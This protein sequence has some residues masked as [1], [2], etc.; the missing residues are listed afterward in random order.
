MPTLFLISHGYRNSFIHRRI[1]DLSLIETRP[2]Q[3]ITVGTWNQTPK[4]KVPTVKIARC[5]LDKSESYPI[6][7]V[8]QITSATTSPQSRENVSACDNSFPYKQVPRETTSLLADLQ[9]P[10]LQVPRESNGAGT[11]IQKANARPPQDLCPSKVQAL[12]QALRNLA[13]KKQA[14][15]NGFTRRNRVLKTKSSLSRHRYHLQTYAPSAHRLMRK[16][17]K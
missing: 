10:N 13:I 14:F 4:L 9:V 17:G 1:S 8:R 16:S 3:G 15:K 7:K 2:V 6:P 5:R 11:I 12:A